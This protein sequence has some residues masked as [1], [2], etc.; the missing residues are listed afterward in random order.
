MQ[1]KCSTGLQ[2]FSGPKER[3]VLRECYSV[4]VRGRRK[5]F[6]T[7]AFAWIK[8]HFF[9]FLTGAV[10]VDKICCAQRDSR[11][12]LKNFLLSYKDNM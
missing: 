3:P 5:G 9:F 2:D 11:K 1:L 10:L 7:G 6:C 8:E 12:Y 4:A